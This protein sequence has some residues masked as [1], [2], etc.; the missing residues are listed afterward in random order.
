METTELTPLPRADGAG[1]IEAPAPFDAYILAAGRSR[2][3]GRPKALLPWRGE[4]LLC[5]IARRYHEAGARSIWGLVAEDTG[6]A[7]QRNWSRTSPPGDPSDPF[8]EIGL[9]LITEV[10]PEQPMMDSVRRAFEH[11]TTRSAGSFFLQPV[12]A[13]VPSREVLELLVHGLGDALV[14]KPQHRGRGGHPL[15]L[16]TRALERMEWRTA[17]SLRDA[18]RTLPAS[19]VRRMECEDAG[20]LHNWNRPEDLEDHEP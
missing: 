16:S 17:D 12:D 4:N 14:A 3:M 1:P 19:S 10:D 9:V 2:R 20:V 5:A 18:I 8:A 11:A 7:L 15:L 6:R 13:G